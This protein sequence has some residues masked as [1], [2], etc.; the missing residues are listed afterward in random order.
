MF[1]NHKWY[2]DNHFGLNFIGILNIGFLNREKRF[3]YKADSLKF[4]GSVIFG[5]VL[6]LGGRPV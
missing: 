6:R 5:F 3:E 2:C 4:V 1:E